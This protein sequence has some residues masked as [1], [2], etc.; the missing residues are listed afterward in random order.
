MMFSCRAV[1][2][3]VMLLVPGAATAAQQQQHP[4]VDRDTF[5]HL[6]LSE[7]KPILDNFAV[8]LKSSPGD[9]LLLIFYG[10][11]RGCRGEAGRW[12]EE[13]KSYLVERRGIE[14]ER[15][16]IFDGGYRDRPT[17]EHYFVPAGATEPE[18]QPTVDPADVRFTSAKDAQCQRPGAR[19]KRP[20]TAAVK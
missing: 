17:A 15:V 16:V 10:G 20:R 8:R 7:I 3:A 5:D 12:G 6:P 18:P 14:P 4:I 9:R 2:A 11:R 19:R 1:L 13:W